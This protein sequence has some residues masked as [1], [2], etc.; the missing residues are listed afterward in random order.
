MQSI[1]LK[2][3]DTILFSSSGQ[4]PNSARLHSDFKNHNFT[5]LVAAILIHLIM[6]ESDIECG[7]TKTSL[8]G[9]G[10][11]KIFDVL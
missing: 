6:K 4:C 3:A 2:E 9:C 10:V 11:N 5:W 1:F 7:H 8:S